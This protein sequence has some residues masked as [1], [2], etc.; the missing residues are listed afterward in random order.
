MLLDGLSSLRVL[1]PISVPELHGCFGSCFIQIANDTRR[2]RPTCMCQ[3][4]FARSPFCNTVSSAS[5][6]LQAECELNTK[7]MLQPLPYASL[8]AVITG[9]PL[10]ELQQPPQTLDPMHP[11]PPHSPP[12]ACNDEHA[13]PP[14]GL[15]GAADSSTALHVMVAAASAGAAAASAALH[16]CVQPRLRSDLPGMTAILGSEF[17]DQALQELEEVV[18]G[19]LPIDTAGSRLSSETSAA[20]L[21]GA[22]AMGA[23]A[24][25]AASTVLDPAV[26]VNPGQPH[27]DLDQL[28]QLFLARYQDL[29]Q[30]HNWEPSTTP[31]GALPHGL[32]G[33]CGDSEDGHSSDLKDGCQATNTGMAVAAKQLVEELAGEKPNNNGCMLL[34][35]RVEEPDPS[36][37]C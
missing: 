20:T 34:M 21:V 30:H 23:E 18:R 14:P 5:C 25:A 31:D 4:L 33:D 9:S 29:L 16:G 24:A 36:R 7:L 27:V 1:R 10:P 26:H 12:A 22:G 37:M 17:L 13:E 6:N 15:N 11:Q 3:R 2:Q 35:R 32:D 28:L 8:L 19:Q